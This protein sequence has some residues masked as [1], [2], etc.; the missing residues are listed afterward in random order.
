[1][2]TRDTAG[3]LASGWSQIRK[4]T[5][6]D[7]TKHRSFGQSVSIDGDTMVIG[8]GGSKRTCSR[9]TRPAISPPAGRRLAK[10]TAQDS[11]GGVSD[12]QSVSIDGDTVVIGDLYDSEQGTESGAA[13]VFTL[14][15]PCDASSP[16]ANGAVSDCTSSL[17]SGASCTPICDSG[18]ALSGTR[19]CTDG[20]LTDTAVCNGN[21]CDASGAIQTKRRSGICLH[22]NPC[23]RRDMYANLQHRLHLIGTKVVQRWYSDRHRCVQPQPVRRIRRHLQRRSRLRLHLHP[24]RT[25][26]LVRRRVTTAT[27]SGTRTCSAGTLTNTAV[28][29][30]NDCTVSRDDPNKNGDDGVFYCINEG[31]V[32]GT[33]GSCLCSECK[34]G[35]GGASCETAGACVLPRRTRARMEATAFFTASTAVPS[36]GVLGHASAR[37]NLNTRERAAR[38]RKAAQ[39][40]SISTAVHAKPAPSSRAA[41]AEPRHHAR[42]QPI[43]S[44]PKV[45]TLG[46]VRTARSARPRRPA[47]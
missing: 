4:L 20:T 9:A 21:S 30:P 22:L 44:R 36:A 33:T 24:Q 37:A 31:T 47:R 39:R 15:S 29:N 23:A 25:D 42:A 27:L 12:G 10:L 19:S 5:A 14:P 8:G 16:P 40:S 13:Y 45:E 18:Y 7:A 43:R 34:E 38:P 46:P 1:M 32:S 28:C 11:A 41:R 26:R 35:Y 2:F 3:N 17:A 6:N